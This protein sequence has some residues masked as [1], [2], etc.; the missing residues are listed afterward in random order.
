[1]NDKLKLKYSVLHPVIFVLL[2]WIIQDF[3]RLWNIDLAYYGIFPLRFSGLIGIFTS[4]LI[5]GDIF[6]LLS[7]SFPLLVLGTM[8]YYFYE[9]IANKTVLYIYFISGI[10]VWIFGRPSYHI[11]AS[12]IVYG[13]ASFLFFSGIFRKNR[14]SL[15]I[16]L[17]IMFLYGSMIYGIFPSDENVSYEAHFFGGLVGLAMAFFYR[18]VPIWKKNTKNRVETPDYRQPQQNINYHYMPTHFKQNANTL[19]MV[20]PLHFGYNPETHS[21]NI[22]QNTNELV[23]SRDIEKKALEEFDSY[24]NTLKNVGINVVVFEDQHTKK[25]PDAVFPNN[26]FST[27]HDGKVITY[28]MLSPVRRQERRED[29]ID[30]LSH[31]LKYQITEKLDYTNYEEHNQFL[32]GTGSII[33]DHVTRKAYANISQRT[34]KELFEQLCATLKYQPISYYSC[35]AKGEEI[36]HTNVILAVGEHFAVVCSAMIPNG[37]ERNALLHSLQQDKKFV[38]DVTEEQIYNFCGNI[39]QVENM[40]GM[41]YIAMSTRAYNSFTEEQRHILKMNGE[42]VHSDLTTIENY[43]GGGARC[44]IAEVFLNR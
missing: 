14:E 43:G 3:E 31:Q 25:L 22:F 41:K 15:S 28:P 35:N 33:F 24:A 39:L 32:E 9:K 11:G 38:L 27:H 34:H 26:W 2:L 1:M 30:I 40:Y 29:I 36:Y 7:N 16:S 5:H 44:M 17:A 23:S 18:K 21:S 13:I 19:V 8:L 6:H 12:G 20:R 42:I 37:E 4:P 10:L